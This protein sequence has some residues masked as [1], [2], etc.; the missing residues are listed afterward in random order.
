M[1]CFSN[2]RTWIAV[3][4]TSFANCSTRFSKSSIAGAILF[5]SFWLAREY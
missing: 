1:V 4:S 3:R 2:F 5:L